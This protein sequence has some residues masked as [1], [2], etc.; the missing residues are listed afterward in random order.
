MRALSIAL[1]E[2]AYRP[3]HASS[4]DWSALQCTCEGPRQAA[5]MQK[6]VLPDSFALTAACTAT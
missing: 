4:G 6:R 2:A 3:T 1:H 5:P